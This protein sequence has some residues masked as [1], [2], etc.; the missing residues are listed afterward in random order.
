[1]K[2]IRKKFMMFLLCSILLFVLIFWMGEKQKP[3]KIV[4]VSKSSEQSIDFWHSLTEGAR[5]AAE[6]YDVD[7]TFLAP[8]QEKDYQRQNELIEQAIQLKPDVIVLS[9]ADSEKT[10]PMAKKIKKEGIPLVLVDSVLKEDI[11]DC[12]VST[13]NVKAGEELGKYM[14]RMGSSE[15]K[16]GIVSHVKESSTAID[17]EQGIRNQLKREIK[18]RVFGESDYKYSYLQTKK[19][20]KEHPDLTAVIATNEY[21]TLG[22][23]H[24]IKDAGLSKKIR[25]LGFD[26]SIKEL[27][28]LESGMIQGIVV[29]RPFDMGYLGVESAVQIAKGKEVEKKIDSGF[30]FITKDT[31]F[32]EEN[33]KLLF[34]IW[35]D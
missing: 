9:P 25:I 28:L 1:M 17:R 19:M 18:V 24:Y 35:L 23:A 20:L 16:I 13:D 21:A 30:S 14:N 10:L 32:T 7:Y 8:I 27:Q 33:Q 22:A 4:Y 29:Q 2:Y 12:I 5:M 31:M 34:P 3:L 6:E 11:A 15:M 26:S